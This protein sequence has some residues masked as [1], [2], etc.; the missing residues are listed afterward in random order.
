MY[1]LSGQVRSGQVRSEQ[2]VVAH[3]Y[4]GH[5]CRPSLALLSGTGKKG[6]GGNEG[7]TACTGRYKG[8]LA[9][10]PG[11]VACGGYVLSCLLK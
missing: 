3:A 6:V 7:G 5:R 11:S 10:R 4:H 8:V 9:V 2:A 1:V